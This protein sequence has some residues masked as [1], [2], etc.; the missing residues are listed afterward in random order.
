MVNPPVLALK[1]RAFELLAS[2]NRELDHNEDS[3]ALLLFYAAECALKAVYMLRNNLRHP[4]ESRGMAQPARS[5]V[6]NLVALA[7]ALNIPR[8]SVGAPPAVLLMRTGVR[9]DISALHQAWRYGEKVNETRVLCA[10]LT[11]LIEWCKKNG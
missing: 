4:D 6:H 8:S 9:G 7:T 10:W 5:F 3:G 2:A 1:R 11:S